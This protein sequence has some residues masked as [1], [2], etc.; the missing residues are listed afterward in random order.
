[1]KWTLLLLSG[2]PKDVFFIYFFMSLMSLFMS[3]LSLIMFSKSFWP[4][5]WFSSI[6]DPLFD[7]FTTVIMVLRSIISHWWQL[8]D[9]YTA[10]TKSENIYWCLRRKTQ[11]IKSWGAHYLWLCWRLDDIL[12]PLIAENQWVHMLRIENNNNKE[13]DNYTCVCIKCIGVVR[14]SLL[15]YI[16]QCALLFLSPYFCEK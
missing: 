3:P 1:M 10:I 12:W 8:M 6:F 11:C 13:N 9:S 15:W 14:H 7:P 16:S 2:W 4:F 5:T